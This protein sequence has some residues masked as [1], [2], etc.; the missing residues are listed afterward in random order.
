MHEEMI[1]VILTNNLPG[2]G[3]SPKILVTLDTG[4]LSAMVLSIKTIDHESILYGY[5]GQREGYF[6]HQW[7]PYK[8]IFTS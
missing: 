2:N 4:T 6:T 8:V 3:C 5:W 7:C 1:V